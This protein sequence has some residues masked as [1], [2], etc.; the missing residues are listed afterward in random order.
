MIIPFFFLFVGVGHFSFAHDG[1]ES[2]SGVSFF[3][4]SPPMSPVT[5]AAKQKGCDSFLFFLPFLL[6]ERRKYHA[7]VSPSLGFKEQD[8]LYPPLSFLS[9]VM[10]A[11][12]LVPVTQW[13]G[14]PSFSGRARQMS[15][16]GTPHLLFFFF[17]SGDSELVAWR[18]DPPLF[19]R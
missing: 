17:P 8:P 10:A 18:G 11:P 12:F 9:P 4:F 19:L 3:F 14:T 2:T 7:R 13:T 6:V 1:R 15:S 5:R 16:R